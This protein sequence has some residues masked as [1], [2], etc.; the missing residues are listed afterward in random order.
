[1]ATFHNILY[2]IFSY[3][4]VRKFVINNHAGSDIPV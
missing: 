4:I 3:K 1:M 2:I